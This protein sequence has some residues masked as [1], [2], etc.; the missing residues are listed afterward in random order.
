MNNLNLIL[1]C[2]TLAANHNVTGLLPCCK[3]EKKKIFLSKMVNRRL[4]LLNEDDSG[5]R[6]DVS[7]PSL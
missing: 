5:L 2:N 4:K 6:F 7:F 3:E 1:P